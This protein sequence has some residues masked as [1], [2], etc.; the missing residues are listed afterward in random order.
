M[1]VLLLWES[2]VFPRHSKHGVWVSSKVVILFPLNVVQEGGFRSYSSAV[3]NFRNL[4]N[5]C[6]RRTEVSLL[7]HGGHHHQALLSF[8]FFHSKAWKVGSSFVFL[9]N[10]FGMCVPLCWL[11]P[12]LCGRG[13]G[14]EERGE[15]FITGL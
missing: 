4:C 3:L 7:T 6:T 12:G 9:V 10:D 15:G 2:R 13:G 14:R 5:L 11:L 1:P 8:D